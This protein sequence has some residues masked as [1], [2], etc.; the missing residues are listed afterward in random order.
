M[1]AIG[2]FSAP[3]NGVRRGHSAKMS[4]KET[5]SRGLSGPTYTKTDDE[6][7]PKPGPP[8]TKRGGSDSVAAGMLHIIAKDPGEKPAKKAKIR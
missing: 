1:N 4:S 3:L 5:P 8:C 6:R 7:C 2:G